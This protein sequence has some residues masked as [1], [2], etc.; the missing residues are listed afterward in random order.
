MGI[1]EER[2]NTGAL[3]PLPLAEE[4]DPERLMRHTYD[5]T[6]AAAR[7][8]ET[9]PLIQANWNKLE[10]GM[11][12]G[13]ARAVE[14]A[15]ED[16][17]ALCEYEPG[18]ETRNGLELNITPIYRDLFLKRLGAQTI[19]PEDIASVYLGQGRVIKK[20]HEDIS[21]GA[22]KSLGVIEQWIAAG[23]LLRRQSVDRLPYFA[24][25]RERLYGPLRN[26]YNTTHNV[27]LV[28]LDLPQNRK[29]PVR[30]AYKPGDGTGHPRVVSVNICDL[31]Q[32]I[33]NEHPELRRS[34]P[35]I[36]PGLVAEMPHAT[37]VRWR[38]IN[39]ISLLM[40]K[41]SM[42]PEDVTTAEAA[43]LDDVSSI[44][45]SQLVTSATV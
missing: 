1:V 15:F 3:S 27:S 5:L 19:D 7:A 38:R 9:T 42:R 41:E 13:D 17:E 23:A 29:T 12:V 26:K 34:R 43:A 18:L 37:A 40:C 36:D 14:E 35:P 32:Q 22:Y 33:M 10:L 25:T 31:A 24:S 2:I 39:F 6:E 21:P 28:D 4:L 44:I 20:I 8:T 45:E 30:A 11:C 16:F